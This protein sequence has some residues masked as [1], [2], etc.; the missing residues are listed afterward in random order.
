MLLTVGAANMAE[1]LKVGDSASEDLILKMIAQDLDVEDQLPFGKF[2]VHA[3]GGLTEVSATCNSHED[4]RT[5]QQ[6]LL[7]EAPL[8]P[9]SSETR[10]NSN[11]RKLKTCDSTLSSYS[12]SAELK[13]TCTV[14]TTL[15]LRK[16]FSTADEDKDSYPRF[17]DSWTSGRKKRTNLSM[18]EQHEHRFQ[19]KYDGPPHLDNVQSDSLSLLHSTKRMS[20]NRRI[21][22]FPLSLTRFIQAV[23]LASTVHPWGV[24]Q[25]LPLGLLRKY[26]DAVTPNL[27]AVLTA[28]IMPTIRFPNMTSSHLPISRKGMLEAWLNSRTE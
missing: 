12:P 9:P 4:T 25:T 1:N 8:S 16:S 24:S 14:S 7:H 20:T 19:F 11:D 5:D 15:P 10:D 17:P 6:L 2:G 3:L 18:E 27:T 26:M 21:S 28:W 23:S 22:S 13:E